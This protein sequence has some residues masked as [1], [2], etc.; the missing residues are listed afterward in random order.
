M[1]DPIILPGAEK[2]HIDNAVKLGGKILTTPIA[3]QNKSFST[4]II[5]ADELAGCRY[6]Q[7]NNLENLFELWATLELVYEPFNEYDNTAI[8]VYY[9]KYK[10]GYISKNTKVLYKNLLF[11]G[12]PLFACIENSSDSNIII[13]VHLVNTSFENDGVIE[14]YSRTIK[15]IQGQWYIQNQ[16]ISGGNIEE[17]LR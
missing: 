7:A 10:I 1:K 3:D 12:L 14:G 2:D 6:Y 13:S 17:L 9:L 5:L 4:V 16:S 8:G 11:S 15:S